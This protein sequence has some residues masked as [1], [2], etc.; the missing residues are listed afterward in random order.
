MRATGT[1]YG[2]LL[3]NALQRT[4]RKLVDPSR[5]P[6][7]V[8]LCSGSDPDPERAARAA[9]FVD[10]V[11]RIFAVPPPARIDCYLTSSPD[12]YLRALGLDFSRCHRAV[13]RRPVV[14]R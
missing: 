8:P 7:R 9:A 5:R 12:E 4:T 11:A 14:K 10:S 1:R 13:E 3:S 2:W 6:D